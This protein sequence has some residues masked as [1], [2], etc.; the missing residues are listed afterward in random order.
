M[1]DGKLDKE[2]F[3]MGADSVKDPTVLVITI[4]VRAFA[5]HPQG[6]ALCRG[7][8]EEAKNWALARIKEIRDAGRK[9]APVT[10]IKPTLVL[11]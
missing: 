6:T 4:P 3:I 1:N 8:M 7:H 9:A 11:P 2:N 10:P 5:A